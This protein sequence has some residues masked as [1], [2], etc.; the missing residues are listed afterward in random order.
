LPGGRRAG[1]HLPVSPGLVKVA[2]RAADVGASA[3]QIFSDNPTAWRRRAEPPPEAA[4]FRQRLAD[5]DIAPL[6]IHAA[7]LVN[8]AGPDETLFARSVEVLRHELFQAPAYGARFIN[9][10][11]GSHRGAGAEAG[12][13]RFVDGIALALAQA[14]DGPDAPLLVVENSSGGGDSIGATVD[15]LAAVLD[16]AARRRVDE[17]LGFCLDTAHL[18]GAGYDIADPAEIDRVLTEFGRLIG[19]GRLVMVHFNDTHS[20]LGSRQDRHAHLG[21]GRIGTAGMAH[22]LHH[23]ALDHVAFYLETPEM[24]KGFDAVNM[25]RL[26]DLVAGRPLAE[27]PNRS[28]ADSA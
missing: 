6:A 26:G 13:N 12:V 11:A 28:L 5:L 23:P 2:E 24:E 20:A 10:H 14:P 7:Y 15:Q 25:A 1:P 21:D 27:G 4:A 19:F 8:L 17:R 16:A 18:W 22:L 9:V 3:L